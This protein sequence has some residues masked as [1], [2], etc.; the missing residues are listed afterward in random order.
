MSK[1]RQQKLDTR[2]AIFDSALALFERHGYDDTTIEEVC[3][4]AGV[5]RATFFRHFET[6]AGLLREFNRRL[7]VEAAQRVEATSVPGAVHHLRLVSDAIHDAWV[8]AGPGL[9][10]L[11]IDA[12]S[13]SDPGGR[14]S[15]PELLDVV[16]GVIASGTEA[17]ELRTDLPRPLAAHIVVFHL[18]ATTVWWMAH[19]HLDLRQLLDAALAHCLQGFAAT[20]DE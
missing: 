5:G 9:R 7:A 15:H 8:D 6:K 13:L 12:A 1:R 3:A 14:R 20:R 2:N 10:S 11:G 17:G 4:D 18:A 19:P 16:A